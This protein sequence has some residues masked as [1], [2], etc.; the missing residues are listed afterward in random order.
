MTLQYGI[1]KLE[2][3]IEMKQT[4]ELRLVPQLN[5]KTT[6][7]RQNLVVKQNNLTDMR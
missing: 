5:S 2:T 6:A 7:A 4:T 1:L 3:K